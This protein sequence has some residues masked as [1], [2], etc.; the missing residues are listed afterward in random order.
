MELA[1]IPSL[2]IG[3]HWL[4]LFHINSLAYGRC[5][6]NLE[7]GISKLISIRYVA[8]ES[9]LRLMQQFFIED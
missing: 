8:C 5:G 7:L 6:S 3:S 4:C 2:R 1:A 9:A